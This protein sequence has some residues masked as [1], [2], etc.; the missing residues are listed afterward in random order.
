MGIG[1]NIKSLRVR[2]GLT[3]E[4][5]ALKIGV[6]PSAVGNY[7]RDVSF[8]KEEA[9]LAMFDALGCSPN[10]LFG[11]EGYSEEEIG[12][13]KKYKRLDKHGKELV[14]ACTEIELD[15]CG[16]ESDMVLIAAR[17]GGT[18]RKIELKQRGK[19]TIF[20]APSYRGGRW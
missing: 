9:L 11:E 10:E 7:E 16:Q 18:A 2:A 8:P 13:L 20:D 1:M 14:D 5:L 12:H 19:K 4:A 3:Q 15:R 6:T 17:N